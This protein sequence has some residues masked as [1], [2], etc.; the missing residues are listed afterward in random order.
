MVENI[1]TL[2]WKRFEIEKVFQVY[3]FK[4]ISE[5]FIIFLIYLNKNVKE[6]MNNTQNDAEIKFFLFKKISGVFKK[7]TVLN[8]KENYFQMFK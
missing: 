7:K 5:A 8:K 2:Y 4:L 3:Q 6:C 1:N